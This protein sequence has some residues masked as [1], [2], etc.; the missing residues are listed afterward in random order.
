M[1]LFRK[2]KGLQIGPS[3]VHVLNYTVYVRAAKHNMRDCAF[4]HLHGT[5]SVQM[6]NLAAVA[7]ICGI[8]TKFSCSAS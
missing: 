4:V 2:A 6:R 7:A 1:Q 3:F 8:S 5:I